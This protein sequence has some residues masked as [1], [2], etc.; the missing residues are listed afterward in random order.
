M[1]SL[2]SLDPISNIFRYSHADGKFKNIFIQDFSCATLPP[3]GVMNPGSYSKGTNCR[4]MD[5]SH[6]R[7]INSNA[8]NILFFFSFLGWGESPLRTSATVWPLYQ[9]RTIDDEGWA[10]GEIRIS[11]GNRS[12]RRK[13][14]PMPLYP[15]QIPHDLTW[16]RTRAAMVGRRRLT[17]LAIAWPNLPLLSFSYWPT[18]EIIR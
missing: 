14:A 7:S 8:Y 13:P 3:R 16:A 11:R 2:E 12:T 9:P 1:S 4:N 6:I 17:A 15:P 10:V 5:T 18:T